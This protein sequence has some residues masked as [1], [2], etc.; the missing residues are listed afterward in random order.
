[1]KRREFITLLGGAAAV[2]PIT[3]LAQQS[4]MPVVGFIHILS[5]ENVP[6]FVPAFHRGL[7]EAGFVEAKTSQSNTAGRM[8]SMTECLS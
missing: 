2:W 7:K 8:A 4:T 1:M 5:P 3:V 6:H